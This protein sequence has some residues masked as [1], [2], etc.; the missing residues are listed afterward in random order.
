[1]IKKLDKFE[2]IHWLNALKTIDIKVLKYYKVFK[3]NIGLRVVL[4]TGLKI[5]NI[6]VF[7][8]EMFKMI[9]VLKVV[10]ICDRILGLCN[11]YGYVIMLSAAFDILRVSLTSLN[12][13]LV[14]N[15]NS[16]SGIWTQKWWQFRRR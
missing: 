4:M 10:L 6:K 15:L 3:M 2:W 9:T 1:L 13:L 11:N 7:N 14:L 5:I 16:F 8:Y 12:K